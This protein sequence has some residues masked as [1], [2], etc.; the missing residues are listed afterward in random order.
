M[1]LFS[2]SHLDSVKANFVCLWE[3]YFTFSNYFLNFIKIIVK[4]SFMYCDDNVK[5]DYF[6]SLSVGNSQVK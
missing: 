3:N 6:S 4:D 5:N 2:N 1:F